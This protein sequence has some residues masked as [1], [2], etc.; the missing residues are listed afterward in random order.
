[1]EVFTIRLLKVDGGAKLL[2]NATEV[3]VHIKENDAPIRFETTSFIFKEAE[4]K[5]IKITRGLDIN[6]KRVGSID[7]QATVRLR[8]SDGTAV[9]NIDYEPRDIEIV[10]PGRMTSREVFVKV[11]KDTIPELQETFILELYSP[12]DNVILSEQNTIT[13]LLYTSPSPRDS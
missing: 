2:S 9:K 11:L 3:E 12:S 7:G 4:T 10:F 1:M 8:T 5:P 13:C 6:K